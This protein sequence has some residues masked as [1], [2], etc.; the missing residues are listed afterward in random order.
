MV[1]SPFSEGIRQTHLALA[2]KCMRQLW[3]YLY[4]G[5][6]PPSY[7]M[8]NG[9]AGHASIEYGLRAKQVYGELPDMG[10]LLDVYT[11][12]FSEE[13]ETCDRGSSGRVDPAQLRDRMT[14]ISGKA[15][16]L[17]LFFEYEAPRIHPVFV[18]ESFSVPIPGTK[19]PLIGT[20]DLLDN[21]GELSDYKFRSG[22]KGS[23]TTREV[24]QDF[25]L[26]VYRLGAELGKKTPVSRTSQIQIICN[27]EKSPAVIRMP[28]EPEEGSLSPES[29]LSEFRGLVRFVE[30]AKGDPE[31]FPMTTPTNWWCSRDWCGYA[32]MCPRYGGNHD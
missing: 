12:R 28:Q 11:T 17:P 29:I 16:A 5:P 30:K 20:V 25:Q 31:L 9:T 32:S 8:V 13:L 10:T 18:E 14:G 7:A 1:T 19:V 6:K 21:Q 4:R 22:K 23:A 15:G 24:N 3:F 2:H 26:Q 27:P